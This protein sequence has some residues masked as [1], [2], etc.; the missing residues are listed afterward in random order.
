VPE[1]ATEVTVK[2]EAD[3]K[4]RLG[5]YRITVAAQDGGDGAAEFD[6]HVLPAGLDP[7]DGVQPE[8]NGTAYFPRVVRRVGDQEVVFVLVRPGGAAAPFYLMQN[9]VW[10]SLFRVFADAAKE[11]IEPDWQKGGM[12]GGKDVGSKEDLYPVFRV[13]RSEAER[14]AAWL[15][16]R[17]PSPAEL[18][19]VKARPRV[20][21]AAVGR[22]QTGPRTVNDLQSDDVSAEGVRDLA[23]NGREWTSETLRAGDEDVAVLA[24]RS[25]ASVRAAGT[26]SQARQTQYPAHR[27]PYTTFRVLIPLDPPVP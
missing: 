5:P 1:G 22:W 24:G 6:A 13:T 8:G 20:R 18:G 17:L 15:G 9:K 26:G 12:A 27:S 4:A 14:F 10:N 7:A 19:Y 25:Y 2:V 11:P 3:Q 23:G 16:G 21:N